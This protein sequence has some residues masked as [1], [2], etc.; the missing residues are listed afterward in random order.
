MARISGLVAESTERRKVT[1]VATRHGGF[2]MTSIGA[3]VLA[4]Q[5]A[6]PAAS[7]ARADAARGYRGGWESPA[8][9]YSHSRQMRR[10]VGYSIACL[11]FMQRPA[12]A[13]IYGF[14]V[15]RR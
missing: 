15:S 12:G 6:E 10:S 9:N 11:I 13:S 14:N 1:P 8:S 2:Q 7:A 3:D 5:S 4:G